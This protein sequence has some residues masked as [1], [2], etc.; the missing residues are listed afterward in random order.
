M[1]PFENKDSL[2]L[3][4]EFFKIEELAKILNM[5]PPTIRKALRN[6]EIPGAI[7]IGKG[8]RIHKETFLKFLN[9]KGEL[10]NENYGNNE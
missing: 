9:F 4:S 10:L 1:E 3:N 7:K 2:E 6:N 8:Y 5:S